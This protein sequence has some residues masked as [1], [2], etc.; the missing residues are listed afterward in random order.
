MNSPPA[1]AWMPSASR[2]V[3]T[4][5]PS[6]ARAS[7]TCT[8][9]PRRDSSSAAVKPARPPPATTT[10]TSWREDIRTPVR[11]VQ[12]CVRRWGAAPD[13]PPGHRRQRDAAGAGG[14]GG[15]PA[16]RL[17]TCAGATRF[18]GRDQ[19]IELT[20]HLV[21]G[22]AIALLDPA[23]ELVA[24][25]AGGVEIVV[26][27][28]APLL[29][30]RTLELHPFALEDIVIHEFV[31]PGCPWCKGVARTGSA[32]ANFPGSAPSSR[33]RRTPACR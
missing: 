29:L 6:V 19:G 16:A 14:P 32:D 5:P 18:V 17:R 3:R 21:L 24:L 20:I 4:R 25:S 11:P 10:R 31:P 33:P 26:G 12:R 7:T 27:Q 2:S 23:N 15:P 1:S 13:R 9:T 8:P 30:D 22:Q 28:L